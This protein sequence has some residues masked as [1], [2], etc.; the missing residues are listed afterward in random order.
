MEFK[1]FSFELA[2]L[3]R[4][5]WRK[6]FWKIVDNKTENDCA[7]TESRSLSEACGCYIFAIRNGGNYRPMYVGKAEI[8]SFARRF[9]GQDHGRLL[10]NLSEKKGTLVVLLL[11]ALTSGGKFKKAPKRPPQEIHVLESMLIGWALRKN[12][13]LLNIHGTTLLRDMYVPGV[14]NP[15]QGDGAFGSVQALRNALGLS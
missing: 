5:Q 8:Q 6:E 13:K 11:A 7:A 3:G 1:V 2:T 12:P 4:K 14:I 9:L 15:C 10:T